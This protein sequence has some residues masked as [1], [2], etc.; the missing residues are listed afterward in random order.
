VTGWIASPWWVAA[1]GLLTAVVGLVVSS[2][3]GPLVG[4]AAS[5]PFIG[6]VWTLC[7]QGDDFRKPTPQEEVEA[8][9]RIGSGTVWRSLPNFRYWRLQ[10]R[11]A[12]TWKSAITGG[13][14][15]CLAMW[16]LTATVMFFSAQ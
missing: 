3:Y 10:P 9:A 7:A 11:P 15:V 2:A 4:L 14:V 8:M 6:M 1:A 13:V 5:A 16:G 12:A